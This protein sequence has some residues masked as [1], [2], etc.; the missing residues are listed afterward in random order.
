M[1]DSNS[2]K[3][4]SFNAL[5]KALNSYYPLSDRTW[6]D[7]QTICTLR[8]F[9]KGQFLIQQGQKPSTFGYVYSGL[10]RAYITD[11]KGK[12]YNKMFFPENTFP[13]SMTALLTDTL[14]N[15]SIEAL[16]HT[17]LILIDF[18]AYRQLLDIHHD[19]KWFQIVYLETN[20]LLGKEPREVALVQEDATQRYL[21][22]LQSYPTLENRL[23]QY[24][25]ASHLGI[26]PTQLSRIRKSLL[27]S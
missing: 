4:K 23:S 9:N 2:L 20:W 18:K 17:T 25:I 19:L 5:A 10:L 3:H 27:K 14:S 16:E 6:Q 8:Q 13:G 26:T 15:F 12:D 11:I 22:F 24:H 1:L 7:I 21:S